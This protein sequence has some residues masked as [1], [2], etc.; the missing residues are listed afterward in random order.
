MS[1]KYLTLPGLS[2]RLL[3]KSCIGS[4]VATF[5]SFTEPKPN[6]VPSHD[7][8]NPRQQKNTDWMQNS[9]TQSLHLKPWFRVHMGLHGVL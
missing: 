5:Q 6:W 3:L 8:L 1:A 7:A 4:H 2:V 9:K